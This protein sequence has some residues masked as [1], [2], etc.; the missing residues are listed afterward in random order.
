MSLTQAA[1]KWWCVLHQ[2]VLRSGDC[3]MFLCKMIS[4]RTTLQQEEIL[5]WS[6]W[7]GRNAVIFK[8]EAMDEK[9]IDLAKTTMALLSFWVVYFFS[10]LREGSMLSLVVLYAGS[11]NIILSICCEAQ[12]PCNFLVL[13]ILRSLRPA[14]SL[15]C[16]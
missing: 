6:I 5:P 8:H 10:A 16:C 12:S 11:C 3:A 13:L 4:S 1:R 2:K 9:I 14:V 7:I 15:S